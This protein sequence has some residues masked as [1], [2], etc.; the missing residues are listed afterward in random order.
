M[1][2]FQKYVRLADCHLS[3]EKNGQRIGLQLNIV[4]KNVGKVN[5]QPYLCCL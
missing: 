1:A 3:G 4:Q 5:G 2:L